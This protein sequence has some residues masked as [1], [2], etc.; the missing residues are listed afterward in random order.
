MTV[1]VFQLISNG[2]RYLVDTINVI[3]IAETMACVNMS[4]LIYEHPIRKIQ[5]ERSNF[6]VIY[7]DESWWKRGTVRNYQIIKR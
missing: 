5:K 1:S 6:Y 3:P 7:V 4:V 2:N